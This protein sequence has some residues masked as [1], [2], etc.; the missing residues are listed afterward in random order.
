ME[1][2][3]TWEPSSGWFPSLEDNYNSG[4]W[5]VL[6]SGFFEGKEYEK[7]SWIVALRDSNGEV[8][9]VTVNNLVVIP[10]QSTSMEV[11]Y[12]GPFT[13]VH[14]GPLGNVIKGG[15]LE[16]ED[17]PSHDHSID[18]ISGIKDKVLEVAKQL[19]G[20]TS[21]GSAVEFTWD[22]D[23]QSFTA[24]LK[25]D[26]LTIKKDEFGYLYTENSGTGSPSIDQ[27]VLD[28]LNAKVDQ[29]LEKLKTENNLVFKSEGLED[30]TDSN[31]CRIVSLKV[32]D[33][34]F[35]FSPERELTLA[36][37]IIEALQKNGSVDEDFNNQCS[38]DITL[39]DLKDIDGISEWILQQAESLFQFDI[40][41]YIDESSIIVNK[42]GKISAVQMKVQKHTH[43]I[44]DVK[45]LAER[46]IWAVNQKLDKD[47]NELDFNDG[48]LKLKDATIGSTLYLINKLLAEQEAKITQLQ[49]VIG[50]AQP[51]EPQHNAGYIGLIGETVE[52]Y[53]LTNSN[54]N[55]CPKVNC[56]RDGITLSLSKVFPLQ[57]TLKIYLNDELY[58]VIPN[59]ENFKQGDVFGK[60]T[61]KVL[62]DYYKDLEQFKGWYNCGTFEVDL[63]DL[64]EQEHVVQ[65]VHEISDPADKILTPRVNFNVYTSSEPFL[66]HDITQPTESRFVSGIPAFRTKQVSDKVAVDGA[67]SNCYLP[68]DFKV[69]F[70]S[71]WGEEP[72]P[73][74]IETVANKE[75]IMNKLDF[76]YPEAFEG[77]ALLEFQVLLDSKT[78][79]D[80]VY[81][82][83]Y[84]FDNSRIEEKYRVIWPLD[85]SSPTLE[86]SEDFNSIQNI[87]NSTEACIVRGILENPNR[88]FEEFGGFDYS[89]ILYSP[90]N[91][92]IRTVALKL[93]IKNIYN[94][95][96]LSFDLVRK[97][98]SAFPRDQLSGLFKNI[99][100]KIG[101]VS[102]SSCL[103][104]INGNKDYDYKAVLGDNS[105][106]FPGLDLYNTTDGKVFITLG[107][108]SSF[109]NLDSLIIKVGCPTDSSIDLNRLLETLKVV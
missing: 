57:G 58:F 28:E 64:K 71:M 67:I 36:P 104:E 21:N 17:L 46:L 105:R 37:T 76:E 8:N 2:F 94:P 75:L 95:C 82:D 93:P 32:D 60:A 43:E 72:S 50:K 61:L 96:H 7:N 62:E 18:D 100:I 4:A 107:K 63:K 23:S 19:L 15:Y 108:L 52:C 25:I 78:Y 26:E 22:E 11:D 98:G 49:G 12:P 13:K 53:N 65:V 55:L 101:L 35:S 16:K 45:G 27:E 69:T 42:D 44:E 99:V 85:S 51:A 84:R 74:G 24:D 41:D 88:N 106:D 86:W 109:R 87:L 3:G 9:Y 29:A 47:E 56:Y 10:D 14:I 5:L 102:G 54:L 89:K 30:E 80:Q 31:G 59:I 1:Y 48:A 73:L 91:S 68:T 20:G 38:K 6:S 90:D 66:L 92:G 103:A 77:Q 70:N 81:L 33:N 83:K 34:I 39:E 97:D 40:R 79:K